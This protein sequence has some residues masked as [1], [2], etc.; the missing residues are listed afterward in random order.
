MTAWWRI[1]QFV[2]LALYFIAC[3]LTW[4]IKE[5]QPAASVLFFAV[6]IIAT[7]AGIFADT[8]CLPNA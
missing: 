6:S 4:Q 8:C 2:I 3:A 1:H 5:W 7:V